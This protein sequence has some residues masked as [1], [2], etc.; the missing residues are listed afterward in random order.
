MFALCK[1]YGLMRQ[2]DLRL[3]RCRSHRSVCYVLFGLMLVVSLIG[4]SG[5]QTTRYYERRKVA[6][7]CMQV[8]VDGQLVYIRNKIEAARE[9]SLGG[10]GS[11]SAG[12]C[13]CQ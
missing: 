5:C 3:G 12:G 11:A 8:G 2:R 7:R 1:E 10:F 4:L 6:D 13:G 9:G